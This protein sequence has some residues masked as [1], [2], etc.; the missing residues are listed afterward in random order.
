VHCV[1]A[2]NFTTNFFLSSANVYT[3]G[4][5]PVQFYHYFCFSIEI[6]PARA[7]S[8]H[9]L[10][11]FKDQDRNF[12]PAK[13]FRSYNC[14]NFPLKYFAVVQFISFIC[15]IYYVAVTS[16]TAGSLLPISYV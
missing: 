9:K 7:L 16:V 1:E 5:N 11:Q 6:F 3:Q 10:E 14:K 15:S 2:L 4:Y 8:L 12:F 13:G